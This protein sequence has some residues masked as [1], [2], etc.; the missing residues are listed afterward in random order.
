[1]YVYPWVKSSVLSHVHDGPVQLPSPALGGEDEERGLARHARGHVCGL[2]RV[3][4]GGGVQ[5]AEAVL[6]LCSIVVY[7]SCSRLVGLLSQEIGSDGRVC[8]DADASAYTTE[9]C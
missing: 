4:A 7:V 8:M 2:Q 3:V 9:D 1:M 6:Q 5:Q